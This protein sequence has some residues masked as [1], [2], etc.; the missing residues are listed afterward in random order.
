MSSDI[1]IEARTVLEALAMGAACCFI[2]DI[3][4]IFR[5]IFPR[6]SVLTGLEDILWWIVAAIAVFTFMYRANGGVVRA[7]IIV[8][9]MLG[10]IIWE[11]TLGK[12][13]VK[14]ISK[15][16]NKLFGKLFEKT[17]YKFFKTLYKVLK[18]CLKPFT[19]NTTDRDGKQ[20]YMSERTDKIEVE[21][22]KRGA[23]VEKAKKK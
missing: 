7:Y 14:Y 12:L 21:G 23:G 5:R 10:M 19:I 3:L 6:G 2:Y 13:I 1:I 16:I 9:M 4:R 11:I 20:K 8:F 18:K 17:I 15:I 22:R